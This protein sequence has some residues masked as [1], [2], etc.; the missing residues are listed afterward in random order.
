M[1]R[2]IKFRIWRKEPFSHKEDFKMVYLP[3]W[4]VF[5]GEDLVFRTDLD[6]FWIDSSSGEESAILM[7]FTG[8]IDKNGKEI[9][10]GDIVKDNDDF[11]LTVVYLINHKLQTGEDDYCGERYYSYITGY[12][13]EFSDKSGYTC[14]DKE[15]EIIGNIYESPDIFNKS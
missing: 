6:T 8:L 9:Y 13:G 14:L 12:F 10:E 2:E 15:L 4:T 11:K 3:K 7:Q 5:D 1:N